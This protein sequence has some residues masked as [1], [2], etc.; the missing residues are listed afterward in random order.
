M[1]A[2]VLVIGLMSLLCTF[3]ASS[4]QTLADL[5]TEAKAEWM[6]GQWEGQSDNGDKVQLGVSWDLD[7]HVVILHVKTTEMESKG[8]TVIDPVSATPKYFS[9]DNRGSVGKGGWEMEAEELV[10][11]VEIQSADRGP[12]KAGLVFTGSATEGLKIRMHS[13]TDSGSLGEAR[14]SFKFKKAAAAASKK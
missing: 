11:R 13:L 7:K 4:Q 9:F 5:V 3:S 8:Y 10:L 14:T 1:I 2:R 6:F 12:W